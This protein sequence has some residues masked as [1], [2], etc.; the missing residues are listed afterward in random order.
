ME[1]EDNSGSQLA[2]HS[3]GFFLTR[4]LGTAVDTVVLWALGRY[5][6][7]HYTGQYIIA[8]VISFEAA[9]LVN[10]ITSYRI[11]WKSRMK[12]AAK[13][14]LP[15]LFLAFNLSCVAGFIIKMIFLLLFERAFGFDA[16]ICNLLALCVSGIFN[17]FIS[18]KIIFR[19]R[20]AEPKDAMLGLDEMCK[21]SPIFKGAW[22]RSLARLLMDLFGISRINRLYAGA[23]DSRGIE[24]CSKVID[25]MGC[26]Y[27]VGNAAN[28]DL[29][30]EEGAFVTVSNHPY[31]GLDGL[32]QIELVGSR[33]KDYKF[34]VNNILARAKSLGDAFITVT[35]TTTEKKAPDA[36]TVSGIKKIMLQLQEGHGLGCFPSGAVSDYIPK[37][38]KLQDRKWQD[39]MLRIIQKAKVPVIPI[40]FPDRNSRFF[41]FLGL[42]SWKLRLLRLPSEY[43]NKHRST[44]RV[45]V[46]LPI[47][48]E[49]QQQYPDLAAYGKMLRDKVYNMPIPEEYT[50]RERNQP[51]KTA[52]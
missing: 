49:E 34:I 47:S 22:G 44:H 5:V 45:I 8:P 4:L 52:L 17:F 15:R 46:G 10:F 41:Y 51:P 26:D 38:R 36:V 33:R 2:K 13:G 30:P 39:S 3:I 11:V 48:V 20:Y 6:F 28:L 29:I 24:A 14:E 7:S 25:G 31:G 40:Y 23:A 19:K 9:T 21:A 16:Y 27:L 35:P 42:I 12:D 1:N 50:P 32:I 37:L 18:E 43:F